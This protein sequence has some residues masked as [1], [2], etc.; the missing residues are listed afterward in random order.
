MSI[1]AGYPQESAQLYLL[2]IAAADTAALRLAS[3]VDVRALV[4]NTEA[5]LIVRARATGPRHVVVREDYGEQL[6]ARWEHTLQAP[7]SSADEFLFRMCHS[8]GLLLQ[9][10][11]LTSSQRYDLQ[12]LLIAC[13]ATLNPRLVRVTT[14]SFKEDPGFI[15][16]LEAIVSGTGTPAASFI[17]A[18]IADHSVA[19]EEVNR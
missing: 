10:S 17:W 16:R 18:S 13:I 1:F 5:R 12:T 8:I 14:T 11:D 9:S 15:G 2:D 19:A 7:P 4:L 6:T 3:F